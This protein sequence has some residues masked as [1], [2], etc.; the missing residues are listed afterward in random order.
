MIQPEEPGARAR[1]A[2]V[3]RT[4]SCFAWSNQAGLGWMEHRTLS[5]RHCRAGLPGDLGISGME[6]QFPLSR[7][8]ISHKKAP[9][10]GGGIGVAFTT[11]GIPGYR[12]TSWW[13]SCGLKLHSAVTAGL[14]LHSWFGSVPGELLHH[15]GIG[16]ALGIQVR[17]NTLLTIGGHLYHPFSWQSG[18]SEIRR[19][20][21]RVS[22]GLAAQIPATVTYYADLIMDGA[23]RLQF[24]QGLEMNPVNRWNLLLGMQTRPLTISWASELALPRWNLLLAF[25][26]QFDQGILPAANL[27]HVW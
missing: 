11:C 24:S 13:W 18:R 12:F 8:P 25:E 10:Q 27:T 15:P 16:C 9:G 14:G 1:G 23:G 2:Y 3:S 22:A 17:I 26:Y 20:P 6:I 21:A 7:T 4:S 5:I 19:D